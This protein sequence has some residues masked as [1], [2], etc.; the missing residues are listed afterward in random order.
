DEGYLP[1]STAMVDI[2]VTLAQAAHVAVITADTRDRLITIAKTLFYPQRF[3]PTLLHLARENSLPSDE[4]LALQTWLPEGKINQKQNDA[5]TTL[6]TV[7]PMLMA[8]E[9]TPQRVNYYFHY[10]DNW[11]AVVQ[12]ADQTSDSDSPT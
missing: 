5:I 3:Y 1:L 12:S 11:H 10:T 7:R 6:R 4:I 9:L 2:R 8:D